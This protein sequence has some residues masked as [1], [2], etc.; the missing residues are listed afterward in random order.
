MENQ[1]PNLRLI[2]QNRSYAR[3]I[4]AEALK[5]LPPTVDRDDIQASAELGLVEAAQSFD[6]SRGVAFK[7]FAYYRIKGAIYDALSKMGWFSKSHYHQLRFEKA[8]N[9]YL[10]DASAEP[11][12]PGSAESQ[13][14][15]L[16]GLTQNVIACYVLSLQDLPQEPSDNSN[17][18]VED[19]LNSSQ[20][21]HRVREALRRLPEKNRQ[22]LEQYY[23]HDLTL[24]EIGRK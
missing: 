1:P 5:K 4:A 19:Q 13:L 16:K 24:D 10:M 22:V 21:R 23:Y 8:A 7:T 17:V 9:D 2:E 18:P 15:D 20:E 12:R 3:A 11:Q 6:A 14:S